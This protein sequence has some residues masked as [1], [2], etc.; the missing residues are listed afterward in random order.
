MKNYSR[1]GRGGGGGGGDWQ[2]L[3]VV[4][5]IFG[6]LCAMAWVFF[7]GF[8]IF[9]IKSFGVCVRPNDRCRNHYKFLGNCPPTP[10][11]S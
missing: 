9:C 10:P 5:T 7:I 6:S 3:D 4:E 8:S 2:L 1:V 11:L